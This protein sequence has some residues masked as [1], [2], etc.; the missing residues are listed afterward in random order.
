MSFR[1]TPRAL[2]AALCLVPPA[3][4]CSDTTP[5]AASMAPDAAA[6]RGTEAPS[7][8]LLVARDV[9]A[10]YA[11]S[12]AEN[13]LTDACGEAGVVMSAYREAGDDLRA[14]RWQATADSTCEALD[15]RATELSD[16]LAGAVDD[17]LSNTEN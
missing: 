15:L 8:A 13:R 10:D 5:G 12:L 7:G 6:P 14:D 16:S 4:G 1:L 3:S 9:S 2:V 17:V 11:T